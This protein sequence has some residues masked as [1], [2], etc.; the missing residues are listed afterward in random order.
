MN[1]MTIRIGQ[2][3]V[4]HEIVKGKQLILGGEVLKTEVGLGGH[5]DGDVLLHA[6]ADAIL[7]AAGYGDLSRIFAVDDPN[8]EGMRSS[9]MLGEIITEIK[10]K[11]YVIGNIDATLITSKRGYAESFPIMI[12]N[13]S[14]L[15]EIHANQVNLKASTTDKLGFV[16]RQEGMAAQAVVLLETVPEPVEETEEEE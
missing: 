16:G 8:T 2:G 13:I 7:G 5:T 10:E 3:Y 14:N 12:E 1:V 9:Y 11:G 15:C 6:I 4:A